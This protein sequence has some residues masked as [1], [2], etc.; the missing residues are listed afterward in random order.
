MV[1]FLIQLLN[2]KITFQ[3]NELIYNVFKICNFLDN[4]EMFILVLINVIDVDESDVFGI[5]FK[6][7]ISFIKNNMLYDCIYR[8][9]FL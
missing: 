6:G 8:F 4:A 1:Y 9:Y 7:N 5:Y 3:V 2:M